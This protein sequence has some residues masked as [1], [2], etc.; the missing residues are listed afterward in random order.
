VK[1]ATYGAKGGAYPVEPGQV[2]RVGNHLVACGDLE[3]GDGERFLSW[4]REHSVWQP[5]LY[6]VDPP[7]SP[8]YISRFRAGAGVEKRPEH[9]VKSIVQRL[10]RLA[11]GAPLLMEMGTTYEASEVI[12]W[13]YEARE[14]FGSNVALVV[15]ITYAGGK[16]AALYAFGLDED[17]HL[18]GLRGTDDE[19][20]PALAMQQLTKAGGV[21][22]DLCLGLGAT[23][24]AAEKT[25]RV[26]WG[27]ELHPRRCSA[28]LYDLCRAYCGQPQLLGSY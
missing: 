12:G 18:E 9:T 20:T 11:T 2:W 3:A 23:A 4:A 28:S 1:G 15:P 13:V 19:L 21:V 26:C 6:Y 7:W 17:V 24:R 25:G 5:E 10:A 8:A 22:V 16:P 27:L 14:P